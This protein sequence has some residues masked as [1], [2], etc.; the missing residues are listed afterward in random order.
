MPQEEVDTIGREGRNTVKVLE[1]CPTLMII[2]SGGRV[3][4]G[5]ADEPWRNDGLTFGTS[6]CFLFSLS[7]DIKIPFHGRETLEAPPKASRKSKS[8]KKNKKIKNKIQIFLIF[9][10]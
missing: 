1:D 5:Y 3:F 2:R 7:L 6:R 4:G 8:D 9:E 10:I